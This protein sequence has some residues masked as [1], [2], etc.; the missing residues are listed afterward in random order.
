MPNFKD[1]RVS[2][3]SIQCSK[4]A[5]QESCSSKA[6]DHNAV[7]VSSMK[8]MFDK[9]VLTC[10]AHCMEGQGAQPPHIILSYVHSLLPYMSC[11]VGLA[12]SAAETVDARRV[13]IAEGDR[14][15]YAG[16]C[17]ATAH[18]TGSLQ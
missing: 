12:Y 9:P 15:S 16:F 5:N 13:V 17:N 1:A 8:W 7:A 18:K 11:I 4:F 14:E 3:C 10:T 2:A 6:L